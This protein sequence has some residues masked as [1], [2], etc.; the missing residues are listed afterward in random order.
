ML[1]Y[2]V[3]YTKKQTTKILYI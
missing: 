2:S 3:H 1:Y